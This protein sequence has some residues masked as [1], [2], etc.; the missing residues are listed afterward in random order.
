MKNNNPAQTSAT[1]QGKSEGKL[2]R[3]LHA[4]ALTALI[5]GTIG[6]LVIMFREGQ[7][8]PRFLLA[9]FTIWVSAPFA[10]LFWA[11]MVSKR[12]SLV[13][14]A[15]FYCVMVIVALGSLAIYSEWIDIKPTGS[16]N[17]FLFVAIPPASLI[18]SAA[19]VGTA[20]LTSRRSSHSK[21]KP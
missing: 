16:A 5:V 18:L 15:T 20:A 11:N 21:E 7:D 17:A 4:M 14:R 19:I 12:W 3:V 8:T 9:L 6:S 2:F 10:A 1:S 13:T